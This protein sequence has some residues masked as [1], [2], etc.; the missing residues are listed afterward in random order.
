MQDTLR[1]YSSRK[2][3]KC[4]HPDTMEVKEIKTMTVILYECAAKCGWEKKP[5]APKAEAK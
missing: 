5:R 1:S 3:P 2:C 4:K